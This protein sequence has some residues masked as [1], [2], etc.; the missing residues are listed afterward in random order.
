MK[1][2][3]FKNTDLVILAGGEGT[4]IKKLL[5][6]YPKPMIKFNS[7]HLIQYILNNAS[8]YNF[9]RIVILCGYRHKIIFKKYHNKIINF[10]KIICLREKKLLGTSGALIN[11]KKLKVNDFVLMNGDTI[12]DVDLNSLT[13]NLNKKKIG[14]AALTKNLNQ[15]S[16]KLNNL[17]L[18][19]NILKIGKNSKIMNGGV[20]FFR[21]KIFTSIKKTTSSLENNLL[22]KL[23]NQNKIDGKIF[24][25]FFIDIG[26]EFYFK[27]ANKKLLKYFQK[28]GVFLDRDGVVNYDYGYVH[29]LQN[30]KLR[31]GVLSGLKYLIKKNYY[32]FI[33]TNQAGIGKGI[34]SENNFIKFHKQIKEK[35]YMQN[36]FFNDV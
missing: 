17:V 36:I 31:P 15:K 7:K 27:K 10:T 13:F 34:Y 4:R 11:L 1:I 26:S 5:G 22:P 33:V 24:N 29:K 21:K 25:N 18:K 9:K 20:Y 30:F 12:F 2:K 6:K 16:K 8:R 32:I 3:N 35:L 14:V 28:P 19:K 23:I